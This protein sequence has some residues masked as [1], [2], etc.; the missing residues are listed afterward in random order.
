IAGVS[1]SCHS[2]LGNKKPTNLEPKWRG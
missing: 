2:A 1:M